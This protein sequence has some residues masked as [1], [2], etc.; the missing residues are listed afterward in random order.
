MLTWDVADAA[1]ERLAARL[2]WTGS[3]LLAVFPFR[4]RL[5][6]TVRLAA[7]AMT[8]ETVLIANHDEA[9]PVC[10]GFIP[11]WASGAS[12]RSVAVDAAAMRTLARDRRGIP[13]SRD[14]AAWTHRSAAWISTMRLPCLTKEPRFRSPAAAAGSASS[15]SPVIGMRRYSRRGKDFVALEPMTAPT[16]ALVSGPRDAARRAGDRFHAAFRIRIDA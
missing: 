4:H 12:S 13:A 10:F 1:Q 16:N 14:A 15:S 2:D 6:M 5:E 11:T 3:D 7:D 8:L 9:V